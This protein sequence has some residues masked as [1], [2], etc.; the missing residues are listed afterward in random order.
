MQVAL[1]EHRLAGRRPQRVGSGDDPSRRGPGRCRPSRCRGR[2]AGPGTPAPRSPGAGGRRRIGWSGRVG[3]PGQR[4]P[5]G[6]AG[7]AGSC[8][9]GGPGL[10]ARPAARRP[11]ARRP[12]QERR[13]PEGQDTVVGRP[14]GSGPGPATAAVAR[15]R[16]QSDHA[17]RAVRRPRGGGTGTPRCRRPSRPCM[18]KP[19]P[20]GW[21]SS[22]R[23]GTGPPAGRGLPASTTCSAS[24]TFTTRRYRVAF[25]ARGR[26]R[27]RPGSSR[28]SGTTRPATGRR[29]HPAELRRVAVAAERDA[30]ASLRLRAPS[31]AGSPV[32]LADPV[33]VEASRG[34][35]PLTRI[36]AG[37]ARRP[38][39]GQ[40]AE[41]G[42]QPVGDPS[43]GSAA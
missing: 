28:R 15:V 26:Y 8:R 23:W 12:G 19:I 6:R 38:S 3:H 43:P 2:P 20:S 11:R 41:P 34:A 18:S 21:T 37:R 29:Q 32:Q 17:I 31:V 14:M 16:Q 42:T 35:A 22:A 25:R 4:P 40:H 1:H 10:A 33:G 5:P 24:Q 36:S 27:R 7:R 9:L 13:A 39:S 30:C